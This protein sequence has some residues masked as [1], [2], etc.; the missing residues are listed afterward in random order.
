[1]SS[2]VTTLLESEAYF[3][4]VERAYTFPG[5]QQQK[6]Y[7]TY[8]KC[9]GKLIQLIRKTR[10]IDSKKLENC[11]GKLG[12]LKKE[13]RKFQKKK[14]RKCQRQQTTKKWKF[15]NVKKCTHF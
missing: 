15:K 11:L 8:L 10:K 7:P 2:I 6:E 5:W 9:P 13:K 4:L 12:L 3:K 14:S 1:M